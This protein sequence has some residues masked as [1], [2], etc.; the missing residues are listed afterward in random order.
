MLITIL[1]ALIIVIMYLWHRLQVI[2]LK[3]VCLLNEYIMFLEDETAEE[4]QEQKRITDV[5]ESKHK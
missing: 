4:I 3:Y 1:I 2:R 5:L